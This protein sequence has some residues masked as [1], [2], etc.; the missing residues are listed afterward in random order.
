MVTFAFLAAVFALLELGWSHRKTFEVQWPITRRPPHTTPTE[1]S[2]DR[3]EIEG[4]IWSITGVMNSVPLT[5]EDF[6]V[7]VYILENYRRHP[8]FDDPQLQVVRSDEDP[9]VQVQ[10]GFPRQPGELP[11]WGMRVSGPGLMANTVVRADKQQ[12]TLESVKKL[13]MDLIP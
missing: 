12:E 7:L 1:P 2:S 11:T 9:S 13:L 8:W 3:A 4:M 10:H 6:T 5:R